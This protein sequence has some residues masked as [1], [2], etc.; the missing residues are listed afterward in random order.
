[1]ATPQALR[2]V[3]PSKRAALRA[4]AH[5]AAAIHLMLDAS[6]ARLH[7]LVAADEGPV[8]EQIQHVEACVAL[9]G[10][11]LADL[12]E[13]A[14]GGTLAT[15]AADVPAAEVV[16]EVLFEQRDLLAERRMEVDI[17]GPL[18]RFW[19]NLSRLKQVIT[20]LVRNAALH[21]GDAAAARLTIS[22]GPTGTPCASLIVADNGTGIDPSRHEAIFEPGQRFAA[23]ET[24]GSGMGLAIV[25]Q[26]VEEAGGRTFVDPQGAGTRFVV[27]LPQ[28]GEST[29]LSSADA[30]DREIG[31]RRWVVQPDGHSTA[32]RTTGDPD[33]PH[34][35]T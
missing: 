19:C 21:G 23:A 14:R 5:D 18:P 29:L 27:E 32:R 6:L 7:R 31:G 17:V 13:I 33:W 4:V 9:L 30:I 34:R 16:D 26:L 35:H 24:P 22:A 15:A 10:Q 8:G 28:P 20:N 1:M 25:R 11:H 3:R 12:T 2:R